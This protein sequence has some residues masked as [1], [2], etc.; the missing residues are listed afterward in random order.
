MTGKMPV[1]LSVAAADAVM[2]LRRPQSRPSEIRRRIYKAEYLYQFALIE[3]SM[4]GTE[5][6]RYRAMVAAGVPAGLQKCHLFDRE[7]VL[8]WIS[9]HGRNV[10]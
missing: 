5:A 3:V 10:S 8:G 7:L 4:A 2:R 9:F 1:L 6:R